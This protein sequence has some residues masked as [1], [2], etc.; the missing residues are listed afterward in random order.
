[1][2]RMK[3]TTAFFPIFHLNFQISYTTFLLLL[4]Y[5]TVSTLNSSMKSEIFVS[6]KE[7]RKILNQPTLACQSFKKKIN[8]NRVL[9]LNGTNKS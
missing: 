8:Y 3:N 2:G 6:S 9:V 1:M 5:I 4:K 7:H